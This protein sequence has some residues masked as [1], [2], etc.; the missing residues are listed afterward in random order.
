MTPEEDQFLREHELGVLAT[1]RRDGSPQITLV[2][3]H[4][5]GLDIVISTRYDRPQWLNITRQPKVAF[6]VQDGRR[7]VLVYGTA[8]RLEAD[9]ARLEATRRIAFFRRLHPNDIDDD[10]KISTLLNADKRVVIRIVPIKVI[11]HD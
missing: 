9:P 2:Y 5:D 11:R 4:Y 3:Y 6:L 1:G 10:T 8:E 7:Y